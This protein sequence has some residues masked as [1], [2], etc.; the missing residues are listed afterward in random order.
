MDFK[1]RDLGTVER[2]D[3]KYR[4]VRMNGD[5]A[6]SL[7]FGTCEMRHFDHGYAVTSHNSQGLTTNPV[8][9]NMD[10]AV[11]AEKVSGSHL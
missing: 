5:K 8:I 11:H 6:R 3:G 10:S 1:N 2:I 9:V 7:T 4:T